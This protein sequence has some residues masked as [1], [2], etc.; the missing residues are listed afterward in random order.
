MSHSEDKKEL[1]GLARSVEALFGSRPEAAE[2]A[3]DDP[4]PTD[5]SDAAADAPVIASGSEAVRSGDDALTGGFDGPD[6]DFAFEPDPAFPSTA[7][8]GDSPGSPTDAIADP[9][10]DFA[11][12]LE[13]AGGEGTDEV[14]GWGAAIEPILDLD[15]ESPA[16]AEVGTED[17]TGEAPASDPVADFTFEPDP[18]FPGE[19]A[20][21]FAAQVFE[22]EEEEEVVASTEASERN[23]AGSQTPDL[24]MVDLGLPPDD[25]TGENAPTPIDLAVDALLAGD[26][27]QVSEIE[28]LAAELV[29]RKEIEPIARSVARLVHASVTRPDTTLYDVAESLMSP[30]VLGRLARRIGTE[31]DEA[32]RRA[33]FS[34]CTS[35]GRDMAEALRNELADSTDRLSRRIHYD[36]LVAMGDESR[37]VIEEMIHDDN[38]FLVRNAVSI[39]GDTG[40]ENAVELVTSALANP[41]SRVRREALLSLAKLGDEEA[42]ELIPG[43]FDDPDPGVRKAAVVAAGELR[44]ERAL[45]PLIALLDEAHEPDDVIP[46]LRALGQIGDP[47]AV[48]SIE[49][50][51]VR[52]LFSKPRTA[53]RIAAHRALAPMG[54]PQARRLLQQALGDKDPEVKAAVKQVLHMR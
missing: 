41:D 16:T 24:P 35:I 6:L 11:S 42:S 4:D 13:L 38:R 5:A 2:A 40:G 23:A 27:T 39:L 46:L 9:V 8:A 28:R 29:E 52:P 26:V 34:I 20:A 54:T 51:A 10:M 17:D 19:A 14:L 45:R 49:R 22:D 18:A 7:D 53:I 1:A 32:R 37:S 48:V 36:A 47:G 50:H 31:R 44:V 30:V 3:P 12:D 33:Y 21:S 15:A 25:G 43:F